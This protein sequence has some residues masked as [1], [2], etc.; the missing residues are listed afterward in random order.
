MS[1]RDPQSWPTSI[2][3]CPQHEIAVR[4]LTLLLSGWPNASVKL[5]E[6]GHSVRSRLAPPPDVCHVSSFKP[7][8]FD[9]NGHLNEVSRAQKWPDE[10]LGLIRRALASG[11]QMLALLRGLTGRTACTDRTRCTRCPIWVHKGSREY[12]C[13]PDASDRNW[14]DAP[15]RPINSLCSAV[16]LGAWPDTPV[17]VV[18]APL[19]QRW[20]DRTRQPH[21]I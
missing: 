16:P 2:Y 5:T 19:L 4:H 6:R 8:S 11:R 9:H 21:P 18:R 7:C 14:P 3:K 10:A 15:S 20:H 13:R 17:P 12:F 1:K